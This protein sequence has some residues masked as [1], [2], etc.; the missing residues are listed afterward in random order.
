MSPWPAFEELLNKMTEVNTRPLRGSANSYVTGDANPFRLKGKAT[1]S[2]RSTVFRGGGAGEVVFLVYLLS[3]PKEKNLIN[4]M[5]VSLGR[6]Q[7]AEKQS[8]PLSDTL[9]THSFLVQGRLC[10]PILNILCIS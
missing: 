10:V 9:K 6:S 5:P 7:K 8:M 2:L 3:G 1:V 4:S